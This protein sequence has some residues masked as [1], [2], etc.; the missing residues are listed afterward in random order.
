[1]ISDLSLSIHCSVLEEAISQHPSKKSLILIT[2]NIFDYFTVFSNHPEMPCQL[3]AFLYNLIWDWNGG[4]GG[5]IDDKNNKYRSSKLKNVSKTFA[6]RNWPL[7][8]PTLRGKGLLPPSQLPWHG[9][10]VVES[11]TTKSKLTI[12]LLFIFKAKNDSKR[13]IGGL[14]PCLPTSNRT[15]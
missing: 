10:A 11:L 8:D 5:G 1:M 13:L 2:I 4:Q 3:G 6:M 15:S 12:L 7:L 14:G 9:N